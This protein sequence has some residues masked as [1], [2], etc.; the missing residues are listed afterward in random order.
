[1]SEQ[2]DQVE[3]RAQLLPEERTVG[4]DDPRGQAEVILEE[5][6][7][8]TENPDPDASTQSGRRSSEDTV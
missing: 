1:M 8:R 4:S 5:S 6:R 3:R 7:D 2:P